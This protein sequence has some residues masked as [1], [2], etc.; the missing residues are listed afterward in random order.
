MI[1][2]NHFNRILAVKKC[3]GCGVAIA[4]RLGYSGKLCP[5]CIKEGAEADRQRRVA[6]WQTAMKA[7]YK[8]FCPK[9]NT[10]FREVINGVK[11]PYCR[12]CLTKNT[13]E[14]YKKAVG[15]TYHKHFV[16]RSLCSKCK[17]NKPHVTPNG[18]V[19]YMCLGCIREYNR[20]RDEKKRA[21]KPVDP[22]K[23]ICPR[24]KVNK[25]HILANGKSNG[26]CLPCSKEMHKEWYAKNRV[27]KQVQRQDG[28]CPRCGVKERHINGKGKK[29]C[30]CLDCGREISRLKTQKRRAAKKA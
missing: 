30:Y 15:D 22:M 8:S 7:K 12:G 16:D 27:V 18:D 24:C 11:K 2:I 1:N 25:K 26:Y 10:N 13:V 3:G 21:A 19:K 14:R 9:C 28:I 4:D 17:V 20:V 5:V 29:D 23:G 6:K